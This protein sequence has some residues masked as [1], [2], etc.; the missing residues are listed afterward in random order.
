M[1]NVI[2]LAFR[3]FDNL[4]F[5][6]VSQSNHLH[7]EGPST[8][9]ASFPRLICSHVDGRPQKVQMLVS[10]ARKVGN[11]LIVNSEFGMRNCENAEFGMRNSE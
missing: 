2:L 5:C 7:V 11:I 3:A 4:N 9:G 8:G 10:E 1:V 6:L